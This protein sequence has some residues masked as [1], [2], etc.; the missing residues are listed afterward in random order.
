MLSLGNFFDLTK[1]L[2]KDISHLQAS[3]ILPPLRR[4][5]LWRVR[6]EKL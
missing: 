4:N 3:I 2:N 1:A 5:R 6:T